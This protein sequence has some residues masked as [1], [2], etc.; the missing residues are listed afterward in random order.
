MVYLKQNHDQRFNKDNKKTTP[1][2]IPILLLFYVYGIENDEQFLKICNKNN[3]VSYGLFLLNAI[4]YGQYHT[5]LQQ[6]YP[7]FRSKA[8]EYLA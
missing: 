3:N 7:D 1:V 8:K 2:Y 4:R 6:M 5:R